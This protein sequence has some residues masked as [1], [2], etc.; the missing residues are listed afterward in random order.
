MENGTY[1]V[2]ICQGYAE[3]PWRNDP[4]KHNRQ[5]GIARTYAGQFGEESVIER[6]E[7]SMQDSVRFAGE[8]EKHKGKQV[9]LRVLVRA[10]VGGKNGAF[11]SLFAPSYSAIL[12]LPAASPK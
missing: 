11:L 4:T 3:T 6:V 8:A 12:P 2:G 7:V 10:K 5:I 1:L 9:M